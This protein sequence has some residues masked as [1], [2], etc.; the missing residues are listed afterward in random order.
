MRKVL[1]VSLAVVVAFAFA[2]TTSS[3]S[4]MM[5]CDGCKME[6]AKD[7]VCAKDMKCAKCDG[8]MVKCEGCKMDVKA[9]SSCAK[10]KACAKC[11]KCPK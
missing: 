9:M 6:M 10:C 11:C 1:L 8:C 5:K 2:C 7:K 4:Q 3:G